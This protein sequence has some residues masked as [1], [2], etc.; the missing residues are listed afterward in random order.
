MN[1]QNITTFHHIHQQSIR[2]K[3]VVEGND[4]ENICLLKPEKLH[5]CIRNKWEV[6]V[7]KVI[8]LVFLQKTLGIR[9]SA[10]YRFLVVIRE[11]AA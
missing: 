2:D 10:Q 7:K 1:S 9:G 5:K 4:Q 6:N 11:T 3:W 8:Y